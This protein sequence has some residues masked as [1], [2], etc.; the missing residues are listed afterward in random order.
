MKISIGQIVG[1][2]SGLALALLGG[3]HPFRTVQ[4]FI[5]SSSLTKK[6][7]IAPL[8]FFH[9]PHDEATQ[10]SS[11]SCSDITKQHNTHH[12]HHSHHRTKLFGKNWDALE[13]EDSDSIQWYLLNCVAGLEMDLLAQCQELCNRYPK[14]DIVRF[15]VPTMKMARSHG[16][17]NVVEDLTLYSGYVFARVRL[18]EEVYEEI[19]GLLTCRSWMGTQRRKGNRRLPSVPLPLSDDEIASFKGLEDDM[20]RDMNKTTEELLSDYVGFEVES[21]VKVVD[22]KHTG[23]DAIVKRLKG[24]KIAIRLFTYGTQFD[25]WVTPS[26]IRPL[27]ELEI[28]RGL[29]GRETPIRQDDF[30]VSIGKK[31]PTRMR[32]LGE[33]TSDENNFSKRNMRR[34]L[35]SNVKGERDPRNRREDRQSRGER[36]RN[37]WGTSRDQVQKEDQNWQSYK[38]KQVEKDMRQQQRPNNNRNA[39]AYD[40][41]SQ[42]GRSKPNTGR[43][44]NNNNNNDD[45][46]QFTSSKNN[47]DNHDTDDTTSKDDDFFNDLMSELS[48]T[49]EDRQQDQ[50]KTSTTANSSKQSSTRN[51][52]DDF[53]SS[54]MSELSSKDDDDISSSSKTT[55]DKNDVN[56]FFSS[57]E[58]EMKSV[59]QDTHDSMASTSSTSTSSSSSSADNNNN[60]G[61][62]FF[63]N[64]EQEMSSSKGKASSEDNFF[65]S[66]EQEMSAPSSSASSSS[67]PPPTPPG[68][69]QDDFF[70]SL[71]REMSAPSSS[72]SPPSSG[73]TEDDFFSML[74][75]DMSTMVNQDLPSSSSSSSSQLKTPS[76]TKQTPKK[77]KDTTTTTTGVAGAD[78]S[79]LTVPLLKGMLKERGLKVSGKKAELI[80]RLI[81]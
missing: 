59:P 58:Q 78:L 74:E 47:R 37:P 80:E 75:K 11:S 16:K 20:E 9:P 28:M 63:A 46:S 38:A 49:L 53:F 76:S 45:W 12:H 54:L 39:A 19:N 29:G 7:A 4:C 21:M 27:T 2:W 64:L 32:P 44:N 23:E 72:S 69:A 71:E 51:K 61:E 62:D 48:D 42:W 15:S 57:M 33:D 34:G 22:G 68:D 31:K 18:C 1:W 17:R 13:I 81:D 5:P 30:D 6:R 55:T 52:E 65:A 8:S 35:M 41:D 3:I 43:N 66:L 60:G 56:D 50:K 67:T 10:S 25:E 24:G 36:T 40:V 26:M 77:E 70:A 73:N 79:K 14:T